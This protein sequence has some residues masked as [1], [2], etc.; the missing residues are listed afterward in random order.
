[1]ITLAAIFLDF[2]S[3]SLRWAR[4]GML[5]V[6]SPFVA[7]AEL[8]SFPDFLA[9]VPADLFRNGRRVAPPRA[10]AG[11]N[12]SR[13]SDTLMLMPLVWLI[14]FMMSEKDPW[15]MMRCSFMKVTLGFLDFINATGEAC[16]P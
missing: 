14:V 1:M 15:F 12:T 3:A 9:A 6:L 11:Q 8:G 7:A 10:H 13:I 2:S 5:A 16:S 4:L